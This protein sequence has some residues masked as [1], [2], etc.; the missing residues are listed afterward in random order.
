MKFLLFRTLF[1]GIAF[2]GFGPGLLAQSLKQEK[3]DALSYLVGEWVGVSKVYQDGQLLK[4]GAAYEKIAYDMDKSILVIELN[5]AFLQ[6][7]TII[8]YD[9]AK[10]QYQYHRFSKEGAAVYPAELKDGHL[11]VWK[12]ESTRFFFTATEDGG[13]REYGESWIDG[14][15]VM[16]FEDVFVNTL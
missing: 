12:N 14:V 8:L 10:E 13:F 1:F 16:T 2:I 7:H 3:M 6:L 15:W 4:E 11:L 5:T 9:E